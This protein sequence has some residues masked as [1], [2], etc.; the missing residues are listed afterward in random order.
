MPRNTPQAKNAVVT[1]CN[2]SQGTPSVRVTT[3]QNTASVNMK[4]HTPHRIISTASSLS[5]AFHFKWRWRWRIRARKSAISALGRSCGYQAVRR[6]RRSPASGPARMGGL[7]HITDELQ[8][9]HRVRTELLGEFVLDRLC[10]FDESRLVD[11][12]D[13]LHAYRL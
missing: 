9:L 7:L 3:S 2:H 12:F 5:N 8:E 1:C 13:H 4:M 6:R 11:V 10:G